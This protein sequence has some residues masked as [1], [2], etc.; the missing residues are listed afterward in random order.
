MFLI[1]IHQFFV[2][3]R[4][5]SINLNSSSDT[6]LLG[7]ER[8]KLICVI[9]K[10]IGVKF[11]TFFVLTIDI[12]KIR[13][14][15]RKIL[16]KTVKLRRICTPNFPVQMNVVN[17]FFFKRK[18]F[19]WDDVYFSVSCLLRWC[20]TFCVWCLLSMSYCDWFVVMLCYLLHCWCLCQSYDAS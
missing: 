9:P 17:F 18:L 16:A 20:V 6:N 5:F 15:E 1:I 3:R 4:S 8:P 7:F 19:F 14:Q 11:Y 12:F 10:L 2:R 13:Q